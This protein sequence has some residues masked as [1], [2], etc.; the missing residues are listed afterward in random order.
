MKNLKESAY[1]L[2]F[3]EE[4]AENTTII[5]R[6]NPLTKTIATF[7]YV[8]IVVSFERHNVSSLMPYFFYPIIVGALSNVPYKLLLSRLAIAMPFCVFAG[9]TNLFFEKNIAFYINSNIGISFGVLSFSSIIIKSILTVMAV[10][11]LIATTSMPMLARQ[12][13]SLHLP[14]SFVLVISLMYRYISVLIEESSNMYTAYLLR[15]GSKNGIKLKDIGPFLG[16]LILRS[17]DKA[18]QIY[19]AMKCRGFS[20]DYSYVPIQKIPPVEWL[21]LI[22]LSIILI[23]FRFFKFY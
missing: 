8:V 1:K 9:F 12:L 20:S 23:F 7:L 19:R 6:L 21:Y 15:S 16:Q 17:F 13:I 10:L 2:N 18:E 3:L 22:I 14:T 4:S 5:H 11:L